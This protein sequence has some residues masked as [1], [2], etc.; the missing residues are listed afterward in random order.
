M[1]KS[2]VVTGQVFGTV[3]WVTDDNRELGMFVR[4]T[5]KQTRCVLHGPIVER[6]IANNSVRKGCVVTGIGDLHARVTK[7]SATPAVEVMLEAYKLHVEEPR[8]AKQTRPKGSIHA[9]M[10]S[11]A[12]Y[13][14]G[15]TLQLKSFLNSQEEGRAERVVCSVFM[16]SWVDCM[17]PEA[18]QNFVTSLH[19]GREYSAACNVE[20]SYYGDPGKEVPVLQLLP[21]D[22]KLQG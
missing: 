14:N 7:R 4:S 8:D 6:F 16:Q 10:K 15:Q 13:W 9:S 11:V 19:V 22:F 17:P 12:M 3:D 1:A 21:T 5:G 2:T 18:R 20:A